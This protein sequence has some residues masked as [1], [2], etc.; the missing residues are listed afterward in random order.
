MY[1]VRLVVFAQGIVAFGMGM[2]V[3][4]MVILWWVALVWRYWVG[5]VCDLGG[6]LL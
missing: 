1:S 3:N 5:E 2:G 6:V 4:V